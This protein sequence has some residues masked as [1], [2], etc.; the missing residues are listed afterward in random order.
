MQIE[1]TKKTPTRVEELSN[2]TRILEV[3]IFSSMYVLCLST[4][5]YFSAGS[6]FWRTS[7]YDDISLLE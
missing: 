1:I 7:R 2:R 5:R 4:A 6:G 3:D